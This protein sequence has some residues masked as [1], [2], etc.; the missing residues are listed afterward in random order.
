MA[1][2][3]VTSCLDERVDQPAAEAAE[4]LSPS[5]LRTGDTS[6][7]GANQSC[8]LSRQPP[9]HKTPPSCYILH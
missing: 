4:L 8:I 7:A 1:V 9:V 2:A 3:A 5:H 6:P